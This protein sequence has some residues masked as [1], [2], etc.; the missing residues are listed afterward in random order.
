MAAGRPPRRKQRQRAWPRLE[1]DKITRR[2]ALAKMGIRS[3]AA[4]F[5]AF[6]VDDLARVV[7]Q[8]MAQNAHDNQIVNAVAEEF[9]NAGVAFADLPDTTS[10]DPIAYN[11]KPCDCLDTKT[12]SLTV[13]SSIED[14]CL[15]MPTGSDEQLSCW[16]TVKNLQRRSCI[17]L[18]KVLQ[19]K[20]QL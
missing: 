15:K 8:K 3:A 16:A 6:T 13:C 20:P 19:F 11:D 1:R 17:K 10:I 18:Q 12:A 14:T 5:A 7:T 9:K 2:A 4:V